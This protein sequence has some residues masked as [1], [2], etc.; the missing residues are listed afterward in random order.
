MKAF[1]LAVATLLAVMAAAMV[2]SAALESPCFDEGVYLTDGYLHARGAAWRVVDHPPLAKLMAALPVLGLHP[3]IPPGDA[4]NFWDYSYSFMNRNRVP[5]AKMLMAARIPFMLLALGLGL[6]IALWT[7]KRFG[8]APAI[9]A[10]LLYALDPNFLAHGHYVGTDLPLAVFF[11]LTVALWSEWLIERRWMLLAGAGVALGLALLSKFSG[12]LLLPL[13]AALTLIHLWQQRWR[14]ARRAIVGG[15]ALVLI[16]AVLVGLIYGPGAATPGL[17]IE[18]AVDRSNAVGYVLRLAGKWFGLSAHPFLLGVELQARH[19]AAGHPAYLLGQISSKGWWYY[20]PVA[21]AVKTPLAMLALL[22]AT[23]VLAVWRGRLRGLRRAP[24]ASLAALVAAVF[25]FGSAFAS[26]VN[27]GL[28]YLLP[29]YPFLFVLAAAS[30]FYWLPAGW[31]RRA[32]VLVGALLTIETA[33]VAPHFL[34]FFNLAAGGPAN[35]SRY[36]LDS[37]IDWGQDLIHLKRYMDRQGIR[38]V[39]LAYFGRGSPEAYDI[40]HEVLPFDSQAV[41][42]QHTSSVAVI[43][44]T[45]LRDLYLQ[46]GAFRWARELKPMGRV[47]YS[48]FVYDLRQTHPPSDKMKP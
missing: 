33:L 24:L 30:L 4:I 8:T 14:E 1:P 9:L 38:S 6:A 23:L 2:V 7:K 44:V 3:D 31:A 34:S 42:P 39:C 16:A 47:G 35:G 27:I 26:N 46:P 22:S 25:C 5:T 18:N 21:F 37:N 45:L 40:P 29:M 41:V 13:L 20:F 17:K 12:V 10:T 19:N 15:L 11:F 36:L 48:M 43:S 28:R 32:A